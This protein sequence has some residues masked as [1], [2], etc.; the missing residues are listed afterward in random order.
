MIDL[1]GLCRL[2]REKFPIPNTQKE[3]LA[4]VR[5]YVGEEPSVDV[6]RDVIKVLAKAWAR[7]GWVWD[8]KGAILL[9]DDE[10][11]IFHGKGLTIVQSIPDMPLDRVLVCPILRNQYHPKVVWF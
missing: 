2:V 11:V 8:D 6:K 1:L 10:E 7:A 5:N 9:D 4:V 3:I